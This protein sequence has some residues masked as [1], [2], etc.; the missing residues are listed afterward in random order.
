M[1]KILL[2]F[3]L[4]FLLPHC[5]QINQKKI[6]EP[7]RDAS[8]NRIGA[9]PTWKSGPDPLGVAQKISTGLTLEQAI[10]LAVDFNPK[11][12]ALFEEIGIA[13]ADLIQAGFYTNPQLETLFRIPRNDDN[14]TNIEL[15]L[16]FRLSD[17]WQV[18][19]RKKVAQDSAELKTYEIV[20]ELLQL[21][22]SVQQQYADCLYH[23]QYLQLVQEIT[24]VVQDLKERINYRYQFGYATKLDKYYAQTKL[25]EWRAHILQ[26][27]AE[28]HASYIELR[29]MLGSAGL[30]KHVELLDTLPIDQLIHSKEQ[31]EKYALSYHPLVLVSHAQIARA[32]HTISYEASRVFDD[33]TIGVAYERDFEQGTSGVGPSFGLSIPLFDTNYGNIERAKYE[34]KQAEKSLFVTQEHLVKELTTRYLMYQSYRE[35]IELY[36]EEAIPPV[37]KAI[38]FS[39]EYFDKMQMSLIVFLDTQIDLFQTNIK[40]LELQ[41]MALHEHSE[42]EYAVGAQ[43]SSVNTKTE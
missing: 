31:L 2:S 15:S 40:L 26:A 12:Q 36:T 21:R 18:P 33:V 8:K 13:K 32:K 25:A 29:E 30:T 43:L 4:L 7:I 41:R 35:Q 10:A 1:K 9:Q 28:L 39:K 19:L 23:Q 17:L 42:L 14:R 37:T 20:S 5:G 38:A 24:Q 22:K 6:F 11:I 16:G 27:H 34:K 3:S